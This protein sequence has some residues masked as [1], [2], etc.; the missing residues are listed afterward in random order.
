MAYQ[1][2]VNRKTVRF[3]NLTSDSV[4]AIMSV[5]P[6]SPAQKAGLLAG[7]CIISLDD[8]AVASVDDIFR[9]LGDWPAGKSVV[10]DFYRGKERLKAT[11]YPVEAQ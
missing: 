10:I 5:V 8:R 4:V 3:H 1:R 7:D 6:G 9:F 11:A 2:K